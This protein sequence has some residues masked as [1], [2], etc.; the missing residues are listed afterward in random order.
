MAE[1]FV[2][3]TGASTAA[4]DEKESKVFK[5]ILPLDGLR[6]RQA[7]AYAL[8]HS[9]L[10]TSAISESRNSSESC[11]EPMTN[12]TN[13]TEKTE[14]SPCDVTLSLIIEVMRG[15]NC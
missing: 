11:L 4:K 15:P 10:M 3:K 2:D 7:A 12:E 13:R 9:S 14:G 6:A 1:P 8:E 5:K